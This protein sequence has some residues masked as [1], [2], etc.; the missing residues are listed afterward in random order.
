MGMRRRAF[1][2]GRQWGNEWI[3]RAEMKTLIDRRKRWGIVLAGGEG[4]RLKPLTRIISGDDRP[5]Q[6]CRLYGGVTLL[7]QARRRAQ[8]SIRPEQIL[9]SLTRA[10]EDFYL[11]ELVDCPS[12]RVVQP[13]NRGTAAAIL[14]SLLVIARKDQNATVAVFP[15]DHHYSDENAMAEAVER[16]FELSRRETG[17]V[18]LLGAKP[19]GAEVEY[20]WIQVG[21]QVPGSPDSFRI[22]GF[23]E[24]PAPL[25]A[26][27]LFDQGSLWN[28]FVMVGKVFAFLEMICS[29]MPGFLKAFQNFPA[30]HAP[31]E[32]FRIT[33][34]LYE[35]LP[36]IDFSAQ[37]L[38]PEIQRLI[39]HRLGPVT[40]SDLGDGERALAALSGG[41]VEP[42]W[43][44]TWRAAKP[45][46]QIG[47][48]AALAALG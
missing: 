3:R 18:I 7:Q 45:P 9:F 44:M 39:V 11:H 31:G 2:S 34:A 22:Q 33:D 28:T 37:V 17:S 30:V 14:S 5:K 13:R 27:F 1:P 20:G 43:A 32:E 19:D 25:V 6:F 16:A 36:S 15:S 4:V 40:W 48:P 26:R 47:R 10:H 12:Q 46:T 35:S 38:S 23:H 21:S 29:A 8:Q 41:G 24:K 42:E